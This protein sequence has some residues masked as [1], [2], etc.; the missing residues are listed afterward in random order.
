MS[1][2]EDPVADGAFVDSSPAERVAAALR[3]R[4]RRARWTP[5]EIGA[6]AL[7]ASALF[8]VAAQEVQGGGLAFGGFRST[9]ASWAAWSTQSGVPLLLLIAA[10][11]A[12][13]QAVAYRDTIEQLDP[14]DETVEALESWDHAGRLNALAVAVGIFAAIVVIAAVAYLIDYVWG[15]W[16]VNTTAF[17]HFF[18]PREDGAEVAFCAASAVVGLASALISRQAHGIWRG[19]VS[20][21]D[22]TY[23]AV[24][25]EP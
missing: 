7:L 5:P 19:L 12:W 11:L 3:D 17:P 10:L 21:D 20:A 14:G 9:V 22:P 23:E 25:D 8:G 16:R 15:F 2:P 24:A 4:R 18:S 13:H 1:G 6:G